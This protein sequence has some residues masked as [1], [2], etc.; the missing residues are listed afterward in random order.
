LADTK[1]KDFSL[2]KNK[3]LTSQKVRANSKI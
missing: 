1:V 2:V 3:F